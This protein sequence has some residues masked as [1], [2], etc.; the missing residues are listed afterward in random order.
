[1]ITYAIMNDNGVIRNILYHCS[2][3]NE[4]TFET[5][6]NSIERNRF[7]R[8]LSNQIAVPAVDSVYIIKNNTL[9]IDEEVVHRLELIPLNP[10]SEINLIEKDMCVCG[11]LCY[12]CTL[13]VEFEITK[14]QGV[15]YSQDIS[16]LF[17]PDYQVIPCVR[18]RGSLSGIIKITKSS[19]KHHIKWSIPVL[20]QFEENE[21][22]KDTKLTL[23][24][25]IPYNLHE[26]L[27]EV[28]NKYNNSDVEF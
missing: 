28:I 17:Y 3:K 26:V 11:S 21:D 2:V 13:F 1:M 6:M 10:S 16:S 23:S 20:V 27:L 7:R 9:F 18:G 19:P 22:E 24:S 15:I 4:L 5:N 14:G 12:K 25:D 8:I